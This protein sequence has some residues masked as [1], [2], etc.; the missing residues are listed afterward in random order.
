MEGLYVMEGAAAT[1]VVVAL[2]LG[3]IEMLV[4]R[5]QLGQSFL[6]RLCRV[7]ESGKVAKPIGIDY[8]R[9]LH[10]IG[11]RSGELHRRVVEVSDDG[12]EHGMAACRAIDVVAVT[13][14]GSAICAAARSHVAGQTVLREGDAQMVIAVVM[15]RYW[16]CLN[17]IDV[18]EQT[19]RRRQDVELTEYVVLQ[20]QVV[21]PMP[22]GIE[23]V[24]SR[25]V[26]QPRSDNST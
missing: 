4:Q 11:S 17:L 9:Y 15:R 10:H 18:R 8:V 26:G 21:V 1:L 14:C 7:G 20:V 13:R 19:W 12:K 24:V 3:E 25:I 2:K 6:E 16:L 5:L 22:L 23:P